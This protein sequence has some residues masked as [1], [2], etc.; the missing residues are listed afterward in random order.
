MYCDYC[1]RLVDTDWNA[2]HFSKHGDCM[3]KRE[4]EIRSD[5]LE[6]FANQIL[7][8]NTFTE[9]QIEKEIEKRLEQEA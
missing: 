9:E 7:L 1:H 3:E 6:E 4:Q 8:G 2:E 5:V